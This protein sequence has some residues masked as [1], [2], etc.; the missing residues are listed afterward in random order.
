MSKGFA[1]NFSKKTSD[2]ECSQMM[3]EHLIDE[4]TI[5]VDDEINGVNVAGGSK[6]QQFSA[7]VAT[8]RADELQKASRDGDDDLWNNL[9][10]VGTMESTIKKATELTVGQ[11]YKI[12]SLRR[13]RGGSVSI[14]I[15]RIF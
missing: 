1:E 7:A 12:I 15:S 10:K 14:T 8:E 4:E 6:K 2:Q 11:L 3:E 13:V 9:T 5:V